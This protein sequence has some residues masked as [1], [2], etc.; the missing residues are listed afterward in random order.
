MGLIT[1]VLVED[2]LNPLSTPE[3][4]PSAPK[5]VLGVG[6]PALPPQGAVGVGLVPLVPAL[7]L[8]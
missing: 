7:E 8:Q 3:T 5:A 6:A 4:W 2:P 1:G